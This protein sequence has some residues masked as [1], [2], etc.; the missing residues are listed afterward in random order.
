MQSQRLRDAEGEEKGPSMA[1]LG[2][3]S[4]I[5]PSLV[6]IR[7]KTSETRSNGLTMLFFGPSL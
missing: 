6:P 5:D 1:R 7:N 4:R 3:G 2:E